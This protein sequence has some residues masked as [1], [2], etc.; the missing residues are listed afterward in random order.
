[1]QEEKKKPFRGSWHLCSS[2]YC[3]AGTSISVSMVPYCHC[4]GIVIV[5][6][7]QINKQMKQIGGP[8]WFAKINWKVTGWRQRSF[9]EECVGFFCCCFW[10]GYCSI[11]PI[12]LVHV[13]MPDMNVQFSSLVPQECNIFKTFRLLISFQWWVFFCFV[14]H[15]W[16]NNF[17]R[18]FFF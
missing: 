5:S 3:A 4:T 7:K 8:R 2:G 17:V 6:T 10:G 12:F 11:L 9:I 15:Q 14:F 18:T 16:T 13:I 1:M